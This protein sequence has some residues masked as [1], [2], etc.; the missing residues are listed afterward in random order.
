MYTFVFVYQGKKKPMRIFGFSHYDYDQA[1]L[2]C[3]RLMQHKQNAFAISRFYRWSK[4]TAV[5]RN[6]M[7]FRTSCFPLN[8]YQT[9]EEY[10]YLSS[11]KYNNLVDNCELF[12]RCDA[13][14]F[15]N[16]LLP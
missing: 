15:L 10:H 2:F 9:S 12:R 7:F 4:N 6:T 13:E 8:P 5:Y 14:D 16:K 1:L 11:I 3:S